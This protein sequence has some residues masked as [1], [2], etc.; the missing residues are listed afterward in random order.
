MHTYV[1]HISFYF[2]NPLLVFSG[3]TPIGYATS[4]RNIT[5]M[6]GKS[7]SMLSCDSVIVDFII[8]PSSPYMEGQFPIICVCACMRAWVCVYV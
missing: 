2:S 7:L 3:G 4:D 1:L 8:V 5:L 6:Q